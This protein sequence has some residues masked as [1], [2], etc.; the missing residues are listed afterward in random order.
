MCPARTRIG[1]PCVR[2]RDHELRVPA[3][4]G[5]GASVGM[6]G[7]IQDPIVV[8]PILPQQCPGGRVPDDDDAFGPA[9]GEGPAIGVERHAVDRA[10]RGGQGPPEASRA[11]APEP[12]RAVRAGGGQH[13]PIGAVGHAPDG[14]GVPLE[15]HL[16][17]V[18]EPVEV[19]PLESPEVGP[20]RR[21]RRLVEQPPDPVEIGVVPVPPGEVDVGDVRLAFGGLSV[22]ALA[23]LGASSE[24]HLVPESIAR[25]DRLPPLPEDAARADEQR[26]A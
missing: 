11:G 8:T 25:R 14:P 24:I 22:A 12:D 1:R 5:E 7:E 19:G 9:R 18:A 4:G 3:H 21:R 10:V 17:P 13:R 20:P 15:R 26:E 23:L 2:I 16:V 6:V